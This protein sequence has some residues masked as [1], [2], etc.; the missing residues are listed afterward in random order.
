MDLDPAANL[1]TV[2]IDG[3]IAAPTRR[4]ALEVIQADA[5]SILASEA[6]ALLGVYC[7]IALQITPVAGVCFPCTHEWAT[8]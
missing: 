5:A 2:G 3:S 4:V 1:A 6:T 7:R 8:L